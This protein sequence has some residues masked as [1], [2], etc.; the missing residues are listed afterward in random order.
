MKA[1]NDIAD[2]SHDEITALID[3]ANRLDQ[4]PEPGPI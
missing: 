1:F 2:F 3:L 4:S